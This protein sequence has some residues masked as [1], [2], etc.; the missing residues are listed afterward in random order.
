MDSIT[1]GKFKA[2][3]EEQKQGLIRSF[4]AVSTSFQ[5]Q[6]EEMA[7]EAD[8]TS[9]ELETSM[10]MRLRNREALLLR[11]VSAA[12]R[13]IEEGSFGDCEC[14]GE[15]IDLRRLEARPTATLCVSCKEEDERRE[16]IHIDGHKPKSL[17]QKI[18]LA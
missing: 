11:K 6:P 10:Q 8:L 7:D 2:M 13:R 14:C 5:L 3:F 15:G 17:G 9:T 12:L 1:L 16:Q 4:E 18:R